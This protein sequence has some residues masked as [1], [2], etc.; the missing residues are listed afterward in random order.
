[1]TQAQGGRNEGSYGGVGWLELGTYSISSGTLNVV[2]GNNAS[3]NFVDADGVL[4]I[5]HATLVRAACRPSF[6]PTVPRALPSARWT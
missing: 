3:G 6:P 4:I 5:A 2:L 1:M